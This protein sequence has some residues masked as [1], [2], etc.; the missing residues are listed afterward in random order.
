MIACVTPGNSSASYWSAS[1]LWRLRTPAPRTS[2]PASRRQH[3]QQ[4]FCAAR[5][6][7][8]G[9]IL[10]DGQD[11]AAVTLASLRD[12][13]A[14]VAQEGG[15][16]NRSITENIR[17]G[18]P[19]A[20]M[21]EIEADAEIVGFNPTGRFETFQRRGVIAALAKRHGQPAPAVRKVFIARD[22]SAKRLFGVIDTGLWGQALIW[23]SAVL[24]IWSMV[25]YLQKAIPEIR[26]RTK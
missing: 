17:L 13:V 1:R 3:D 15:L 5:R 12:A 4:Q 18:R 21:A 8:T 16:F 6:P 26:A 22:E 7:D 14:V 10:I 11:I 20:N 24:T 25:Y 19:G 9:R 2:R 23:L